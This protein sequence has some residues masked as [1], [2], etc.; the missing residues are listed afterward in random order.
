M[1]VLFW[2]TFVL[3][4]I[5]QFAAMTLTVN[6]VSEQKRRMAWDNLRATEGRRGYRVASEMGQRLL[7]LAA[8]VWGW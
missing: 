2:P 5:L 3:Q 8:A 7:S 1:A 4:I 6:T